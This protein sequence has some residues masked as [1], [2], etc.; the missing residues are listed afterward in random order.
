MGRAQGLGAGAGKS[1]EARGRSAR[2]PCAT[3]GRR[4]VTDYPCI[5]SVPMVRA[6]LREVQEPGTGKTETRR[7]AWTGRKAADGEGFRPSPWQRVKAGDRLWVREAFASEIY[8]ADGE[9]Q[10]GAC[11][12]CLWRAAA[13]NARAVLRPALHAGL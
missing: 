2:Y 8:R 1:G 12:G 6:T 10:P 9:K 4:T 7:S 11:C 3:G 13:H 5:M